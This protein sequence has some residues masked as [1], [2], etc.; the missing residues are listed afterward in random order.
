MRNIRYMEVNRNDYDLQKRRI[1]MSNYLF[2]VIC[3]IIMWPMLFSVPILYASSSEESKVSDTLVM[4]TIGLTVAFL[5]WFLFGYVLSFQGNGYFDSISNYFSLIQAGDIDLILSILLQ[6]CFF[7]YA[8]GMF[9]GTL[10]HKVTWPFFIIFTPLWLLFV[11]VPLTFLLWNDNGFLNQMGAIDFS[12][13]MVVHV[14]AGLTSLLLTH[15]PPLTS[16]DVPERFSDYSPNYMATILICFGWFGFNLGPLEAL[17][18]SMGL[19][20]LNTMLA[21]FSSALGF[22][23]V[24]REKVAI[25]DLLTGMTVGLVTSTALVG[26]VS[27]ITMLGVTLFSG[28]IVC[29]LRNISQ[30]DDPVDSFILNAIGGIVGTIGLALFADP[31]FTPN[32][33]VGFIFDWHSN[34]FLIVQVMA[35]AVTVLITYIGTKISMFITNLYF[36]RKKA[37]NDE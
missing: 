31:S 17:D 24:Q 23:L 14:S 8:V 28:V 5:A 26:Y 22:L 16:K 3:V 19:I 18:T 20:I 36:N 27:P 12:G 35:L 4:T 7:L 9:I 30:I 37:M 11:Y 21:I 6:G 1:K 33:Q 34:E 2:I 13:G 10:I 29:H 32:G 25:D 15:Y